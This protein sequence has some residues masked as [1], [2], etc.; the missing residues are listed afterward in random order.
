M[1]TIPRPAPLPAPPSVTGTRGGPSTRVSS[2]G[3]SSVENI[4]GGAG[5][6]FDSAAFGYSEDA[7]PS[8]DHGPGS[9]RDRGAKFPGIVDAPTQAFAAMLESADIYRND[10]DKAHGEGETAGAVPYVGLASKAIE[11]YETNARVTAGQTTILGTS[12]SVVL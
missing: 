6:S 1:A 9:G 10:G 12:I 5:V 2:S 3:G 8:F 7:Q 4:P 11:I